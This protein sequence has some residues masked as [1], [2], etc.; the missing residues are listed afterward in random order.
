MDISH[1]IEVAQIICGHDVED[2]IELD[3][4]LKE[5]EARLGVNITQLHSVISNLLPMFESVTRKGAVVRR[6]LNYNGRWLASVDFDPNDN[7][8]L[9]KCEFN[10]R[11][12]GYAVYTSDLL[13]EDGDLEEIPRS[14]LEKIMG[15]PTNLYAK[16]VPSNRVIRIGTTLV[17]HPAYVEELIASVRRLF[18]P[19]ESKCTVLDGSD[20]TVLDGPQSSKRKKVQKR[21]SAS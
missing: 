5:L 16:K 17:C 10:C 2:E 7:I 12:M 9:T 14:Y 11:L 20:Q 19:E 18:T 1:A 21:L 4:L 13:T 15:A 8:D 3:V 6:G